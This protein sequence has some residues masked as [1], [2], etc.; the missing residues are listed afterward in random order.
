MQSWYKLVA[1]AKLNLL[2]GLLRI[3]PPAQVAFDPEGVC[4]AVSCA[5]TNEILL[6]D[7]RQYE[8]G[9]FLKFNPTDDEFLSEFSY[10]PIMPEWSKL[11]F[12]NDGANI[13]VGTKAHC[14]YIL[15]A[16]DG[17]L[18]NRLIGVEPTSGPEPGMSDVCLSPDGR[19]VFAGMSFHSVFGGRVFGYIY[20]FYQLYYNAKNNSGSTNGTLAMYDLNSKAAALNPDGPLKSLQPTRVL[21]MGGYSPALNVAFNPKSALLATGNAELVSFMFVIFLISLYI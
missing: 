15:D 9:P 8:K 20:I 10:P 7:M 19:Y 6:Y 2:K 13:L 16:F 17:K 12:S 1:C 4:M 18:K 5:V 14:H 11:E 3:P 21:D